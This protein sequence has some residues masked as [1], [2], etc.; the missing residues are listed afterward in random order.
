MNTAYT[1]K[2]VAQI[3]GYSTNSIYAFLKAGRIRGVRVGKGR[4]RI[5]EEELARVMHLSK[6]PQTP[7]VAP[8]VPLAVGSGPMEAV[9]Q[10][11][12]EAHSSAGRWFMPNGFDWLVGLGALCSGLGLFLFDQSFQMAA[13]AGIAAYVRWI[14]VSCGVGVLVSGLHPNAFGWR[15]FFYA[16]LCVIGAANAFVLYH[17][18]DIVGAVLFGPLA[19]LVGIN[20]VMAMDGA[21]SVSL[22]LSALAILAPIAGYFGISDRVWHALFPIADMTPLMVSTLAFALSAAALGMFWSGYAKNTVSFWIVSMLSALGLIAAAAYAAD[23]VYWSRSF[24]LLSLAASVGLLPFYT[25]CGPACSAKQRVLL[26]GFFTV[27]GVVILIVIVVVGFLQQ[28]AWEQNREEFANKT[29]YGQ[30]VLVRALDSVEAT[31]VAASKNPDVLH[32]MTQHDAA[33]LEELSQVIYEGNPNVRRLVFVDAQ[34]LGLTLYPHGSFDDQNMAFQDYFVTVRETRKPFVSQVFTVPAESAERNGVSVAVPVES[35]Q[36]DFLGV[37][38]GS[39][40]VRHLGASVQGI[41]VG[42]RKERFI[43]TDAEGNVVISLR[44]SEIGAVIPDDDPL[45]RALRGEQGVVAAR[46]TDGTL[47]MV[48]YAPV[49]VFGWGISLRA[50]ANRVYA[51]NQTA[52]AML[53][54]IV[55]AAIACAIVWLLFLHVRRGRR[56]PDS[57]GP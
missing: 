22:Y 42:S 55:S 29:T 23:A 32:A 30:A 11:T 38:I 44:P 53:L 10:Q 39:L 50:P 34:G 15:R 28:A 2:Q 40:D 18:G 1:V 54:G 8:P 7:P 46:L 56:E 43:L 25:H 9:P 27:I 17:G 3:L 41:A 52:I 24:F 33:R 48:A 13:F 31:L 36:N 57:G 20:A 5:S 12:P 14:L 37:M 21:L 4:F 16:I 26:N 6:R 49:P 45:R 35:A 19:V 51:I 47:G